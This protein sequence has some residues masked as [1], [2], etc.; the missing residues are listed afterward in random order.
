MC[1]EPKLWPGRLWF[2]GERGQDIEAPAF[3]GWAEGATQG[4]ASTAP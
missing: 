3:L 2:T 1:N 4:E